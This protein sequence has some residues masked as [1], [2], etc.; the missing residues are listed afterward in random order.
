[1]S[2]FATH[3]I[4]DVL[5]PPGGPDKRSPSVYGIPL[6]SYHTKAPTP[7][8]KLPVMSPK[9]LGANVESR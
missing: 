1:M 3:L 9:G 7:A 2:V 4:V 6:S 5:P 8:S